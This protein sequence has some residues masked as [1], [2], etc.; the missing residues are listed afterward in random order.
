MI[1]FVENSR[2][3]TLIHIDKKNMTACLGREFFF[4]FDKR[5][6]WIPKELEQTCEGVDIFILIMAMVVQP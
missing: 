1:S 3:C 2:K 6:G 4:F 5:E